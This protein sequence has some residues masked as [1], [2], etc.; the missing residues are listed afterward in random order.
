MNFNP[1]TYTVGESGGSVSLT[2]ELNTTVE[3]SVTIL[4]PTNSGSASDY[5]ALTSFPVTF[6]PLVTSQQ[7]SVTI[8]GDGIFEPQEPI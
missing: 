5:T 7:F 8:G 6:A 1:T 4:V 3:Y 2:V